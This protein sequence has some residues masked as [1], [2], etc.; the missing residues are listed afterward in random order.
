MILSYFDSQLLRSLQAQ[1]YKSS[2]C[3]AEKCILSD[4]LVNFLCTL[5]KSSIRARYCLVQKRGQIDL[6]HFPG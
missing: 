1:M 3:V 4:Y 6:E 5:E 2:M